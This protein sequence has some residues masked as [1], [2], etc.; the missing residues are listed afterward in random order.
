MTT[1]RKPLPKKIRFEVFKRDSF[2]CQYCGQQAPDVVLHVDHI[3]PVALGGGNEMINLITSCAGCNGGKSATPLDDNTVLA[4]QRAQLVELN[5]RR[6]QLE[7]MLEWRSG[8]RDLRDMELQAAQDH[9]EFV[10][11]GYSIQKEASVNVLRKLLKEFGLRTVMDAM[12]AGFLSYCVPVADAESIN[13]AWVKLGGICR[14]LKTPD[15]QGIRYAR[16]ILRRRVDYVDEAWA[17]R[18]LRR[19][20]SLGASD[21]HMQEIAARASSWTRWR[22]AMEDLIDDLCEGDE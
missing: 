22:H 21:D 10:F 15:E 18:I 7:L 11:E 6:E 19:A 3:D 5:E 17:M 13:R 12:D 20:K 14:N 2:T 16:G 8:M 9:F 4:K 1:E